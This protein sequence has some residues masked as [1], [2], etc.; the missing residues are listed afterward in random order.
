VP[1]PSIDGLNS[2]VSN[3]FPLTY[4]INDHNVNG[5]FEV[6]KT[7]HKALEI[8]RPAGPIVKYL[9]TFID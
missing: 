1:K 3:C 9:D 6:I 5:I 4:D 2:N 8:V 7:Y